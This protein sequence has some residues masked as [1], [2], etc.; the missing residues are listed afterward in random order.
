MIWSSARTKMMNQGV[1]LEWQ[2][3]VR[4]KLKLQ[5]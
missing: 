3:E 5:L 2:V 1:V 4:E